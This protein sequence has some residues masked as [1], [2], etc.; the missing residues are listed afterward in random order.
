[1][2]EGDNSDIYFWRSGPWALWTFGLPLLQV[3]APLNSSKASKDINSRQMVV[4]TCSSVRTGLLTHLACV[5]VL[6]QT[7]AIIMII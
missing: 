4:E 3:A 5:T 1:M 2:D 6:R 7:L